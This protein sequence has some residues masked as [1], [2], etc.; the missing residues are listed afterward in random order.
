VVGEVG[1]FLVIAARLPRCG[2]PMW[3]SIEIGF[4]KTLQHNLEI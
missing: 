2:R 3:C 4:G 1:A